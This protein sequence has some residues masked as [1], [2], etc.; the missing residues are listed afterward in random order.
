MNERHCT[1]TPA[2][3]LRQQ[4][5]TALDNQPRNDIFIVWNRGWQRLIL[6]PRDVSLVPENELLAVKVRWTFRK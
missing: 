4:H 5:Q 3:L 6:A 2:P 1:T